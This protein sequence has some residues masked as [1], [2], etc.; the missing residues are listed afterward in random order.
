MSPLA[1]VLQAVQAVESAVVLAQ[2]NAN[3]GTDARNI[4]LGIIG[5]FAVV[6][7]AVRALGAFADDQYGK[8]ITLLLA[9]IPVFGFAYFPDSTVNIITGLFTAFTG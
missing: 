7:L 9:S 4:V 6:V 1:H 5:T 2:L 3:S 8:M